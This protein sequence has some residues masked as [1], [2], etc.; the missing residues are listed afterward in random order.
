MAAPSW[1]APLSAVPSDVA[2]EVKPVASAEQ[3]ANGTAGPIAGS[4][5]MTITLS[6]PE[7]DCAT[8]QIKFDTT[9]ARCSRRADSTMSVRA[10]T[11]DG[12]MAT[13]TD[14]Q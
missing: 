4:K 12:G 13:L 10:T 9:A 1:L 11:P 7:F 5:S 8:C 14:F 3:I 2:L 6:E